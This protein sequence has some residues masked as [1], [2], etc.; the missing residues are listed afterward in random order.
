[1]KKKLMCLL[2]CLLMLVGCGSNSKSGSD[3]TLGGSTSMQPL[4]EKIVDKYNEEKGS[5]ITVQGGGSSVGIEGAI[6]GTYSVAMASRELTG[7]EADKLKH[8]VICL[9]GIVVIVNKDNKLANLSLAQCKDIFTG[10]IKNW[11]ELGGKDEPIA[12]VSREE[13][14]GT[15]DGFESVVGMESDQLVKNAEILNATG[16]VISNVESN[17]NA[18]GYISLGSLNEKVNAVTIDNVK[19]SVD[20]VKNKEYKLQRP[21]VLAYKKETKDIK[22][23]KD[24]IFS[25]KGTKMI[26]DNGFV[27]VK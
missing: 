13:G 17:K 16:Q 20:T 5:K 27:P 1:M 7:D 23:L 19:A 9:D 21:F 15:R 26:E 6:K 11:K 18:I 10:K 14:S 25:D 4:M 22:K 12:V 2:G 24:Y 3:L 8:E